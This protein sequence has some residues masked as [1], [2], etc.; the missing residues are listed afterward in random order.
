MNFRDVRT[1]CFSGGKPY[2]NQILEIFYNYDGGPDKGSRWGGAYRICV[3]LLGVLKGCILL[4]RMGL[5]GL[6][7]GREW[8]RVGE[9]RVVLGGWGGCGLSSVSI[10]WVWDC[11]RNHW[12]GLVLVSGGLMLV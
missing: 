10:E 11:L 6:G 5:V 8:E 3:S 1:V 7:F 9:F 2:N 12:L 4:W